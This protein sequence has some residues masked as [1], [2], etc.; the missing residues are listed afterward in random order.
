MVHNYGTVIEG[1]IQGR[2][3]IARDDLGRSRI[4]PWPEIRKADRAC[5]VHRGDSVPPVVS[6]WVGVDSKKLE[7][8]VL[9]TKS[10]FL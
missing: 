3:R 7:R 1:I 4:I 10:G 6:S 8:A 5:G 2:E 9:K